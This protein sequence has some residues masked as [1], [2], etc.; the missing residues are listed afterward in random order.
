[1]LLCVWGEELISLAFWVCYVGFVACGVI[2]YF[3]FWCVLRCYLVVYGL[4]LF[5]PACVGWCCW[6]VRFRG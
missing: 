6:V 1:M 4:C 3:G 5:V 2:C